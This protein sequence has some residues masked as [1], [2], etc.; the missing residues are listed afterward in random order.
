M[1]SRVFLVNMI[2]SRKLYN[3]W[4]LF[5]V[6]CFACN[7]IK[8][9]RQSQVAIVDYRKVD[10]TNNQKAVSVQTTTEEQQLDKTSEASKVLEYVFSEP[11]SM[12]EV[13][14]GAAKVKQLRVIES[15]KRLAKKRLR[16]VSSIS[17]LCNRLIR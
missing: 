17:R 9:A 4:F 10:S 8:H 5:L 1:L 12:G 15:K 14:S 6:S 11:V 2:V 3:F 16:L 13:K 7:T